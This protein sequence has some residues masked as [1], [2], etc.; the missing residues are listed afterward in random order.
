[1]PIR[2][3][4]IHARN[5]SKIYTVKMADSMDD[6]MGAKNERFSLLWFH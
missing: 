6:L 3:E 1:M 4:P 5:I 2:I